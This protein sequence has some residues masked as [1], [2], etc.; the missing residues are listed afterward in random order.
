MK[1]RQAHLG[2]MAREGFGEAV[3]MP[4]G[5]WGVII[6]GLGEKSNDNSRN[7][8]INFVVSMR[9]PAIRTELRASCRWRF[10]CKKGRLIK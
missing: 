8:V 9:T 2:G 4:L 3:C 6:R 1:R 5:S 7:C 10:F